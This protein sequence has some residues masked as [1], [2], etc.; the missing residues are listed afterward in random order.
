[1]SLVLWCLLDRLAYSSTHVLRA[2]GGHG[3]SRAWP[4]QTRDAAHQQEALTLLH[5]A[6]QPPGRR[7]RVPSRRS[8]APGGCPFH[9]WLQLVQALLFALGVL[10]TTTLYNDKHE[11]RLMCLISCSEAAHTPSEEEPSF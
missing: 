4:M 6:L 1:M 10:L 11:G 7:L 2:A 5:P 3:I 8:I 9:A